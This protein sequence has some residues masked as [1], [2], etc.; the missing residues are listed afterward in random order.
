MIDIREF[1][2]AMDALNQILNSGKEAVLKMEEEDISVAE[3]A[4]FWCGTF[5]KGS[6]GRKPKHK[7]TMR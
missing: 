3:H 1:P 7:Q 2:G 4:R 5:E 6:Q